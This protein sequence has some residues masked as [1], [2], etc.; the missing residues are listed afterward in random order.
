MQHISSM[1]PAEVTQSCI[2]GKWTDLLNGKLS[3]YSACKV[4]NCN[5]CEIYDCID[6]PIYS[7]TGMDMCQKTPVVLLEDLWCNVVDRYEL[8]CEL[9]ACVQWEIDFLSK[10]KIN[11]EKKANA[12]IKEA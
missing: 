1:T 6:C 10:V 5:L 4:I 12:S 11:E 9:L 2:D 8:N 3:I 7:F